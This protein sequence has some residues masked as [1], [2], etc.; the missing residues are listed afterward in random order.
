MY[1]GIQQTEAQLMADKLACA[2]N[3]GTQTTAIECSEIESQMARAMNS[4]H[5]TA[6]LLSELHKRLT[7][8]MPPSSPVE[9]D[10][11]VGS[12]TKEPSS[13]LGNALAE[14]ARMAHINNESI[15]YILN[16][17]KL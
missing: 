16:R 11:S 17:I 1:Q 4:I 2:K 8:V 10:G 6:N 13:P 15:I 9:T 3:T 12:Q 7:P 5:T 14:M